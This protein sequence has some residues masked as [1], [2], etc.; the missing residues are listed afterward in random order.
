LFS[1]DNTVQMLNLVASTPSRGGRNLQRKD[2]AQMHNR[3]PAAYVPRTRGRSVSPSP[4]NRRTPARQRSPLSLS[5]QDAI[6]PSDLI[7]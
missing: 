7:S 4:T 1:N 2:Y 6:K 3:R 5:S